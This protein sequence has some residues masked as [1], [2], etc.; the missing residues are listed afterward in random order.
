MF[1]RKAYIQNKV[2]LEKQTMPSGKCY[3]SGVSEFLQLGGTDLAVDAHKVLQRPTGV[4][5]AYSL[6]R[7][8]LQRWS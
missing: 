7:G 2:N 5:E 4:Y 3:L 6:S 8:N 1:L